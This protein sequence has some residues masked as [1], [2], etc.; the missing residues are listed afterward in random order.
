MMFAQRRNR[1]T[2]HFSEHIPVVKRR[3]SVITVHRETQAKHIYSL[4]GENVEF[5]S[6]ALTGTAV[7]WWIYFAKRLTRNETAESKLSFRQNHTH[8]HFCSTY[9]Q[10]PMQVPLTPTSSQEFEARKN[11]P[12]TRRKLFFYQT[13][14]YN[15]PDDRFL[16]TNRHKSRRCHITR[17]P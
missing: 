13:A 16:P 8:T 1:L 5:I 11:V 6:F 12:Q 3:I 7:N 2:T 14:R 15:S 4:C 10:A 17:S 9:V